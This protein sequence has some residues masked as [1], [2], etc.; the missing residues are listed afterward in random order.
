MCEGCDLHSAIDRGALA[1]RQGLEPLAAGRRST[2]C[3][4]MTERG[5]TMAEYW[6]AVSELQEGDFLLVM[7]S[8]QALA[9][10]AAVAKAYPELVIDPRPRLR[11]QKE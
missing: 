7:T 11:P 3:P 2:I 1:V 5:P 4:V 6:F 10:A 9:A 8:A